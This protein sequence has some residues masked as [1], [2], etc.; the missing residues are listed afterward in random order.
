MLHPNNK[1]VNIQALR[2]IAV[3]LVVLFH[4]TKIEGKYGHGNTVL[5]GLLAIGMSGVDLFF[6]I[7][8]F[9]MVTI[10]RGWFQKTGAVRSFLYHRATRI[11]PAYWFYS[12]LVLV[13]FLVKPEMVNSSAGGQVNIPESFLLLPQERLPL[14]AV[15]WTLIHE[16][17]FYLIFAL[18][19]V[20]PERR[21][22]SLIVIWG[23]GVVGIGLLPLSE[24]PVIQLATNPLTLEFVA[25]CL[26]ARLYFLRK[27]SSGWPC[28][29]LAL[30][31]WLVGY[32]VH[33]ELGYGLEPNNWWRVLLFGAPATLSVYALVNME[34]E[35]GRT[36]P[37]WI[38]LIGDAAFSIYLSHVLVISTLGRIWGGL[39]I[40]GSGVNII[41]LLIMLLF[42]IIIGIASYRL[43]ERPLLR[44]TRHFEEVVIGTRFDRSSAA[45][46]L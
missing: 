4:L 44:F 15:G 34:R 26:I 22:S 6:V 32:G 29:V 31:W 21:L 39:A 16:I 41:A 2:G 38:V 20:F 9:V 37:G 43:L 30:V 46:H 33:I 19:M 35:T 12:L 8:G 10:T 28:L 36:L 23:V 3:L 42:A 13:V 11:Y 14:L 40:A 5:P 18:L 27:F 24:I 7:S 1:I 25:G 17:Y 45:L